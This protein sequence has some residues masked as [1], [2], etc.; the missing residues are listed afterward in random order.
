MT[1]LSAFMNTSDRLMPCDLAHES[2]RANNVQS[3]KILMRCISF[4]DLRLVLF[5]LLGL[6]TIVFTLSTS[7]TVF[8]SFNRLK[9]HLD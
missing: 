7:N 8:L 6:C 4:F 2:A 3:T 9:G 1:A 5:L